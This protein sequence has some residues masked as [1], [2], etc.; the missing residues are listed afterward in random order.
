VLVVGRYQQYGFSHR[1]MIALAPISKLRLVCKN[2][3]LTLTFPKLEPE[4]PKQ[5]KIEAVN[6]PKAI[7]TG[8][9]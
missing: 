3:V 2:G 6:D 9:K 1:H 8:K 7:E 5:L 4:Q